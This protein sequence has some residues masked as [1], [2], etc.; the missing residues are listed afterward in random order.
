MASTEAEKTRYKRYRDESRDAGKSP[1]CGGERDA[2]GIICRTCLDSAHRRRLFR[3]S[4]TR[5]RLADESTAKEHRDSLEKR[6]SALIANDC[7]EVKHNA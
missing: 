5:S 7:L 4:S 1:S 3:R 6:I 2:G